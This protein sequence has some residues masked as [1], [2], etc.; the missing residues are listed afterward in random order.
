MVVGYLLGCVLF[1]FSADF[2]IV[3]CICVLVWVAETCCQGFLWVVWYSFLWARYF[4]FRVFDLCIGFGLLV[5]MG[6]AG[7]GF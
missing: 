2:G 1:G 3:W 7:C 6:V 4:V 5:L